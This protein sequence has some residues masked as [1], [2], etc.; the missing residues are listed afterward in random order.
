LAGHRF[1]ED[2]PGKVIGATVRKHVTDHSGVMEREVS[3]SREA[4]NGKL[5]F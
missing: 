1:E 3:G 5:L 2:E 4:M